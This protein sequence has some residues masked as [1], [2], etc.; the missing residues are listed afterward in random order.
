MLKYGQLDRAKSFE[1]LVDEYIKPAYED[2]RVQ[3]IYADE[4]DWNYDYHLRRAQDCDGFSGASGNVGRYLPTPC[5]E[6]APSD[7]G[8]ESVVV[9]DAVRA[10][11]GVG[12]RYTPESSPV[13]GEVE[14]ECYFQ[15]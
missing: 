2:P 1:A 7:G 12:A 14:M 11:S 8:G 9:M 13:Y 10:L 4:V 6:V 3:E 5:E 15:R